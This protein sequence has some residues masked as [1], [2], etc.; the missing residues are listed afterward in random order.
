[1]RRRTFLKSLGAMAAMGGMAG[2][3]FR[4]RGFA[5]PTLSIEALTLDAPISA[6][7]DIVRQTLV[8][9]GVALEEEAAL[10][11]TLGSEKLQ[12]AS[13]SGGDLGNEEIELQLMVPFSVQR[14]QDNAYLLDQQRLEATTT[15][16]ANDSNLLVRGDLREEAINDLRH[17]IARQLVERLRPLSPQ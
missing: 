16:Q 8:S 3:G 5:Q 17:E 14:S 12:E 13:L 4:L 1:M 15:Y 10:R 2:C 7:S 6:L 11:L 9:S